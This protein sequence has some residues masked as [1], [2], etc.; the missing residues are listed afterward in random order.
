MSPEQQKSAQQVTCCQQAELGDIQQLMSA[1]EATDV[2]CQWGLARRI[3]SAIEYDQTWRHGRD[4][5]DGSV[6]LTHW[7]LN[8]QK[9]QGSK[10]VMKHFGPAYLV[11][12]GWA[13]VQKTPD[14]TMTRHQIDDLA[15]NIIDGVINQRDLCA[16]TWRRNR[17]YPK[18][19]ML[20]GRSWKALK[21][22]AFDFDKHDLK[23][24]YSGVEWLVRLRPVLSNPDA[25]NSSGWCTSSGYQLTYN[26]RHWLRKNGRYPRRTDRPR[27]R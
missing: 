8:T 3:S 16:D 14:T 1:D 2:R 13:A 26:R 24:N 25:D 21:C 10:Q 12:Y 17:W 6:G 27:N 5:C 11:H 20:T 9:R 19:G 15:D 7:G 4:E 23:P 18:A 22:S